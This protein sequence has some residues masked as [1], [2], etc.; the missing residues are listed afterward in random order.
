MSKHVVKQGHFR[1]IQGL[2]VEPVEV[3]EPVRIDKTRLNNNV[4]SKIGVQQ[5]LEGKRSIDTLTVNQADEIKR[6]LVEKGLSLDEMFDK[7]KEVLEATGI[8]YKGSDVLK[9]LDSLLKLHQIGTDQDD[10]QVK[11]GAVIQSKSPD[12]IRTYLLQ[13]TQKVTHYIDKMQAQDEQPI[14]E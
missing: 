12:E 3:V 11:V 1:A 10:I 5:V 13:I 8:E 4:G 7:Y 6:L 9:A 14:T 2:V